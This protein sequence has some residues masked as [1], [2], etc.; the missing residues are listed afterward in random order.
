VDER[1]LV[2]RVQNGDSQAFEL[3]LRLHH[4]AVYGM[5]YRFMNDHGAADDVVQDSFVKAFHAIGSFRGDSSFKSWLLRIAMNTAKNALRARGRKESV[6]I[7]EL[8]IGSEHTDFRKLEQLQTAEL[9]KTCV[10]KL[11]LRQRQALE[12]RIYEDM[13]F[14]EVADVMECP[15]DT[16]KANFR[17]ALL[18]LK[19][20]LAGVNNGRAIEELRLA[21]EQMEEV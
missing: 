13:S 7:D 16:A 8:E 4:R 19:K 20:L 11:P 14:Q 21:F 10:E 5:A 6:D 17:H 1:Q 18:N 12:L 15:F 2:E 3:L 9:L